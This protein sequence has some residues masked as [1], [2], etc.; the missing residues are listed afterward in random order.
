MPAKSEKQAI[1]ARIARGIQKGEVKPKAGTAS[2]EMAKMDPSSLKDF[3]KM[4][5]G[6]NTPKPDVVKQVVSY[7]AKKAEEYQNYVG[8]DAPHDVQFE[9]IQDIVNDSKNKNIQSFW[10]GLSGEQQDK[11]FQMIR[12]YLINKDMKENP[13]SYEGEQ[14]EPINYTLPAKRTSPSPKG[15]D[16]NKVVDLLA[17][18]A[19]E[20]ANYV[21]TD[22]PSNMDYY[23][24][25]EGVIDSKTLPKKIVDMWKALDNNKRKAL[26]SKVMNRVEEKYEDAS[27]D[28][29]EGYFQMGKLS[30]IAR[31]VIKENKSAPLMLNGKEVDVSSI[32]LDGVDAKD[33]PDFSDA[34]ISAAYYVDGALLTDKEVDQLTSENPELV[35]D[36]AHDNYLQ[37]ER[38]WLNNPAIERDFEKSDVSPEEYERERLGRYGRGGRYSGGY[39][40]S[41][42]MVGITFFN[43]PS[44]KEEEAR[45]AGLTQF[46]S[47]KWGFKHRFDKNTISVASDREK[48]TVNAAEAIF[49]KGRYWEPKK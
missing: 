14:A 32:E 49:G 28:D 11:V 5:E 41:P 13:D 48:S 37:E 9:T 43:V 6:T 29:D 17:K 40:S 39:S 20:W 15:N 1:A 31:K 42:N 26:F 27:D 30:E 44:G 8:I 24:F 45:K 35:N 2:A 36:L 10:N 16:V 25:V 3:T 46:K 47:G 12:R 21:D 38:N 33:Y 7:L 23:S 19:Y 34:Y 18:K 22:S 4:E